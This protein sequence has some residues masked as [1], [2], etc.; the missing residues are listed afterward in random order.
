MTADPCGCGCCTPAS[1]AAPL[2]I[3]NVPGLPAV[4]YRIGTYPTFRQALVERLAQVVALR[5]LTARDDSDYAIAILDGWAVIADILTFYSE[6]TINEAFL[7]TAL[8]RDS[9]VRLSNLVGYDPNP[10]LA[11]TAR[12]AYALEPGTG[13]TIV[14][15]A[16]VQ[17][18]PPPGDNSPPAK[19]ETLADLMAD[20]ALNRVALV[21][22][23]E[24][25]APLDSDVEDGLLAPDA[26]APTTLRAGATLIAWSSGRGDVELKRVD[27]IAPHAPTAR[28]VW[29]PPLQVAR[30]HLAVLARPLRLLGHDAPDSFI[31][32]YYDAA[33]KE[34]VVA[35]VTSGAPPVKLGEATIPYAFPLA[36]TT[37]IEL[38]G[39]YDDLR[40]GVDLLI[41]STSSNTTVR[42]TVTAAARVNKRF[43]PVQRTVTQVTLSAPT[44][45]IRDLRTIELYELAGNVDLWEHAPP[46]QI[47]GATVYA[48]LDPTAAPAV[49]RPVQLVDG[50]SAYDATIVSAGPAP[51]LP[52][53]LAVVVTPGPA[54]PLNAESA[55]LL[56]N[57]VEASH[58]EAVGDELLGIGDAS[59]AGQRFKLAKPPITRIPQAGAPHGGASTLI[60]R[61]SGIQW[62]EL[63][64]LYGS[65]PQ[66]RVF[67][68]ET[69]D[70][71]STY[72]RFGDGTIGALLPSGARVT[73]DYRT[74]LGTAG[75]VAAETL[76]SALTRPKG[77]RSVSNP[78]AAGGGGDA[79]TIDD[80]RLNA[81][82]TVRTFERIVSLRDAEDQA[83]ENA[84][85]GK[86]SAAWTMVGGDPGVA[87]TVAGAG[88]AQLGQSQ[89]AG[90]R[91]DLDARRDPNRPM[92]VRGYSPLGLS[93]VVRLIAMDADRDPK[94]VSAA[95]RAALLAHF[96]FAVRDFGQ[97]VRLSEVYVAAQ[98]VPGVA[99]VD[100]DRLTL[101]DPPQ[102]AAHFLSTAAVQ[103]RIDLTS[104]E[105]ATLDADNLS[106]KV[107]T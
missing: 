10:G 87:V 93:I 70:D 75:N 79:E 43:G 91:A 1:A 30:E 100:V 28:V 55:A 66:D 57:V 16:K 101:C 67:V 47:T 9:V 38:D 53:H 63:Q 15:G 20:A 40:V 88:G 22:P 81:P 45:D 107:A 8:L 71:G 78:L 26:T 17:S 49:G 4:G 39:E 96:S 102:L 33:L 106:V 48:A 104:G 23:P 76:T 85:V 21:A 89:L 69:D 31:G 24:L 13:F 103:D 60:V 27:A 83:R 90:L 74:G 105:L 44:P 18:V 46:A 80:A 50:T 86:A 12:L 97:P 84:M 34:I 14:A 62:T 7:R 95:V 99:G 82:T 68:V 65:G 37:T 25:K 59:I 36:P 5:N 94:D 6:R 52:G 51:D 35:Q 2:P 56:G 61:V 92:L 32:T 29:S 19:F 73:S 98:Q 54:G 77:L 11:A 42:A 41:P 58:G 64:Y 3:T 72:V